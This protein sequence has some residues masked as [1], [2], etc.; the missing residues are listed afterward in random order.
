MSE[1]VE[2]SIC[3]PER[4]AA[5]QWVFAE[6]KRDKDAGDWRSNDELQKLFDAEHSLIFTGR[7]MTCVARDWKTYEP[8]R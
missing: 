3:S 8:V 7:L 2:F 1:F 6:L 5:L 4:F